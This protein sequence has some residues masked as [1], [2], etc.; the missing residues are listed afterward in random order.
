MCGIGGMLSTGALSEA[1][2]KVLVDMGRAI[3]HRGPDQ[4]GVWREGRLGLVHRRLSIQDLSSA[5]AQP[6]VSSSG[7]FVMAFNGEIYNFLTLKQDLELLGITFRGH[8][9]TE[10][11][12][13][14]FEAWGVEESLHRFNGMFAFALVD[15]KVEQLL[16]A[17]DRTGE[18]PLY[19][20]WQGD[21]LLFGSELKAMRAHPD[22]QGK[23][24]RN[25]LA[26]LLRHNFI[27]GPHSIYQDIRKLPPATLIRFDLE[28]KPGSW[29]EPETYW[30]LPEAF[31]D[32]KVQTLEEAADELERHL[33]TVIGEQMIS[34]VPL[35][36]FLSGGIDSSTVVAMMQKQATQQVRTFSI[37]F[38]EAGFNEAEH[39]KAVAAHLGTEHTELY[40]SPD[41]GLALIPK[42][43]TLYDEPF[44]DSSQIPTY[45]VSEMTRQHVTV[46]L[47]GD[48]GDE[49]FCGYPRYPGSV[50]AW[51][52]RGQLKARMR[53]W[54]SSLPPELVAGL[55]QKL[56]PG[57]GERA[58]ASLAERLRQEAAVASA[59]TLAER[60]RQSVSFWAAPERLVKNGQEPDYALT[61]PVP[62]A[63]LGDPLKTLM[64]LDLNWYLPDDILVKVDRAAMACSLETRVPLLD[65]RIVEFALGLP[66]ELN[67]S[68][69]VGKR[70][71][72][73]VLYRY[74]PKELVERPKQGFAVPLGHWLRTSLRDW[75]EELLSERR[76]REEGYFHPE[77][78]RRLWEAHLKGKDDHAYPLWGVLMFQAWLGHGG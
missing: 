22:W 8:S 36:A 56:V 2:E 1:A 52:R 73:E 63:V 26:L 64:W 32:R 45:L 3:Q 6:M 40:V 78:I 67:Y 11:M 51:N 61:Q 27:P 33:A 13:A 14:A 72:R 55:V 44:A 15:R 18:K 77:P 62:K 5:G 9:D 4:E 70:V 75:A 31:A 12:L 74:V 10:V 16:L 58:R 71:L 38:K 66:S 76:L 19:Y 57:Q 23:I 17:R 43:P 60:Y 50:D 24:D 54:A 48:G 21:T 7:R 68:G 46:A 59:G 53:Q 41:D 30:S 37:G 47:S 28:G 20:G 42:L 34:D 69:G 29:P 35:G 49:L 39:A 65:R 25:A